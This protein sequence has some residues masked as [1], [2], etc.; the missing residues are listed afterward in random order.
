MKEVP[1]RKNIYVTFLFLIIAGVNYSHAQCEH[2]EERIKILEDKINELESK[3]SSSYDSLENDQTTTRT[4]EE[5][6]YD[7]YKKQPLQE[8]KQ[9]PKRRVVIPKKPLSNLIKS[10]I[11]EK[12]I[13]STGKGK[14]VSLLIAYTNIGRKDIVS[15]KGTI[16]LEDQ[17]GDLLT[18][19]FIDINLKIPS[20]ESKSGF[21]KV[22]YSNQYSK[23]FKR[24]YSMKVEEIK[25]SLILT[26]I[27]FSDGTVNTKY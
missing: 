21:S 8:T 27:V 23:G 2:L 19:F 10:R 7:T 24:L 18:S 6:K 16:S 22:P 5:S 26:E 1:R 25:T 4:L 12:D 13:T 15:F 9:T 11:L 20:L 17:S 14:G 3:L